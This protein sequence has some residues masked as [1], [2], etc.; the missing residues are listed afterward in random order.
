MGNKSIKVRS[1][2]KKTTKL[3]LAKQTTCQLVTHWQQ[4]K[5]K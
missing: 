2:E 1:K 4:E 5:F 3:T